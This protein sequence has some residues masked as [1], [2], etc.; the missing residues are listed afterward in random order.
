[1][2]AQA[3]SGLRGQSIALA[4]PGGSVDVRVRLLGLGAVT[5]TVKRPSG[6]VV[7]NAH[8]TLVRASFPGAPPGA[9][10]PPASCGS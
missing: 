6:A 10:M 7:L 9:P 4:P 3:T 1:V 2:T 5:V 8:V